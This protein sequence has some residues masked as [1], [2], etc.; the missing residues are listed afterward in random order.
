MLV[1]RYQHCDALL[2]SFFAE[3]QKRSL[4]SKD[5]V[6]QFGELALAHKLEEMQ[7]QWKA[8]FEMKEL[9]ALT[10]LKYADSPSESWQCQTAAKLAEGQLLNP[11]HY[12]HEALYLDLGC[13]LIKK[14]LLRDNPANFPNVERYRTLVISDS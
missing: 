7:I 3:Y 12:M 5:D 10:L 1:R 9:I 6:I 4:Q 2:D 13:P 14:E 11:H 8:V